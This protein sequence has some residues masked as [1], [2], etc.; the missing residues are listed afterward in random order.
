[1]SKRTALRDI[2]S[3]EEVDVP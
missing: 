3:L 1:M 2:A